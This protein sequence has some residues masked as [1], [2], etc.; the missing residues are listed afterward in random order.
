MSVW[1]ALFIT[2]ISYSYYKNIST[3]HWKV[4]GA[5]AGSYFYIGNKADQKITYPN[6]FGLKTTVNFRDF[7]QDEYVF[8][9]L[10]G[11][12]E[13]F[14]RSM[15]I[16]LMNEIVGI[17]ALVAFLWL[18]SEWQAEDLY[19][20]LSLK[21]DKLNAKSI[22]ITQLKQPESEEKSKELETKLENIPKIIDQSSTTIKHQD[23]FMEDE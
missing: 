7:K 18:E 16:S 19:K 5:W 17:I 22:K 23:I 11:F 20:S 1:L 13:L 6:D 15:F 9:V 2:N 3:N 8:D 12:K 21:S 14:K 4:L 10:F